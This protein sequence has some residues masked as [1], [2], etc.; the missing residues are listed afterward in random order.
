[1]S[2]HKHADACLDSTTTYNRGCYAGYHEA[3]IHLMEDLDTEANLVM[4]KMAQGEDAVMMSQRL[5]AFDAIRQTI[6]RRR[7][8]RTK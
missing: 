4:D 6:T 7:I 5:E 2:K 8:T 3:L 1:M